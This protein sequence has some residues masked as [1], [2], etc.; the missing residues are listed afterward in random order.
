RGANGRR[1]LSF[2]AIRIHSEQETAAM[3]ASL[4]SPT[5]RRSART[6]RRLPFLMA[7]AALGAALLVAF[8][9]GPHEQAPASAGAHAQPP[10]VAF[11]GANVVP[12]DRERVIENQTVIVR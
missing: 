6:H 5:T 8:A 10:V 2:R 7:A 12:M 11:V 3:T 1:R 9:W 4:P